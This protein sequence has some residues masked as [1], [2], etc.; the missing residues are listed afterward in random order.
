MSTYGTN[1]PKSWTQVSKCSAELHILDL[2]SIYCI[3]VH[4]SFAVK[5]KWVPYYV[6]VTVLLT[7]IGE[8]Y[9]KITENYI[10]LHWA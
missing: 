8:N 5:T 1:I 10:K 7:L 9:C 3:P 4:K 6:L 2:F